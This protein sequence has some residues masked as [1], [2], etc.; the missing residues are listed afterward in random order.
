MET[1]K[2]LQELEETVA[3]YREQLQHVQALQA[4]TPNDPS[5]STLSSDLEE[6]IDLLENLISLKKAKEAAELEEI[7]SGPLLN[8][9][10][11]C[12]GL[13]Q[14]LWYVA[15][16]TKVNVP[17]PSTKTDEEH[18]TPMIDYYVRYVGYGNTAILNFENRNIKKYFDPPKE[19]LQQGT[20]VLAV[21]DVDQ[22]YYEAIIDTVT[23][24]RTVWVTFSGFG[25][26]QETPLHNIRLLD[27][28]DIYQPNY[29][30]DKKNDTSVVGTKR[31]IDATGTN[32]KDQPK[33]KKKKTKNEA[34]KR[35]AEEQLNRRANSWKDFMNNNDKGKPMVRS[36]GPTRGVRTLTQ[37][38]TFKPIQS[39]KQKAVV[40]ETL[41]RDRR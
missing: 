23:E 11:Y 8:V 15:K 25:N 22:T 4:Q 18:V 32:G 14:G 41:G 33:K 34:K 6:A 13:Y 29:K 28:I 16:I 7:S 17:E 19:Y 38:S 26:V 35:E 37:A 12:Y 2:S 40:E 27:K 3:T 20:R 36:L 39:A 31:K 5:F 9:G 10:D 1:Q 30:H 24:N 21:Y